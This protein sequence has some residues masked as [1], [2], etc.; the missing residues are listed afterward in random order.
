M[1][2]LWGLRRLPFRLLSDRLSVAGG[3]RGASAG[4]G[5][6]PLKRSSCNHG[7]VQRAACRWVLRVGAQA[8][9]AGLAFCCALCCSCCLFSHWRC[10]EVLPSARASS[11]SA[12]APQASCPWSPVEDELLQRAVDML[13]PKRWSAIAASVPGTPAPRKHP[14]PRRS[15]R[16]YADT[17]VR[18]KHCVAHYHTLPTP[19]HVTP[20][21][22]VQP[23]RP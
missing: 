5:P 18:H 14:H 12:S 23:M 9:P 6:R 1:C 15:S 4:W 19:P 17:Y 7:R 20:R 16:P 11:P 21:R 10:A 3:R 13:G 22:F 8:E 2:G